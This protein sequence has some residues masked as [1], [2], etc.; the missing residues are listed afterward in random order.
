L[1]PQPGEGDMAKL[2]NL[3]S[4]QIS[5]AKLTGYFL[6]DTHPDGAPKARFLCSFGFSA[7][8]PET[9][10]NALRAH[11][12]AHNVSDWRVT[13]FGTIYETDGQLVSPDGQN[14]FVRVVWMIDIGT[15]RPRLITVVPSEEPSP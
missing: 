2:P 6:S 1:P 8:A 14:P 15:D 3:R 13:E 11:A 9:L 7:T 4:C 5:D 10:R 12:A